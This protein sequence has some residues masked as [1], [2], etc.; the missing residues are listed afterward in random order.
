MRVLRWMAIGVTASALLG[1]GLLAIGYRNARA[2]PVTRS[3]VVK[4]PGWPAGAAPVRVLVWSDLHLG[5][6]ATD[7]ARLARLVARA[8]ALSGGRDSAHLAYAYAVT[9]RRGDAER[10]VQALL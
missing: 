5:N 4:L 6:R 7:A 1:A 2:D 10:I 8:A 9:G 3:M